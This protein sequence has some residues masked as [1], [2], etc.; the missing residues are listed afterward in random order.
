[1]IN[2]YSGIIMNYPQKSFFLLLVSSLLLGCNS[3]NPKDSREIEAKT[4][5]QQKHLEEY[6]DNVQVVS[7]GTQYEEGIQLGLLPEAI[8]N[9]EKLPS[10]LLREDAFVWN[11]NYQADILSILDRLSNQTGIQHYLFVGPEQKQVSFSGDFTRE[12]IPRLEGRDNPS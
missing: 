6:K 10:N 4:K 9:A 3:L 5:E 1:M 2:D 11:S 8:N 7:T 12:L